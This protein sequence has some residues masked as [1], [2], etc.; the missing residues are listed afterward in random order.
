MQQETGDGQRVQIRNATHRQNR[1][2]IA[3]VNLEATAE[4]N[5][6]KNRFESIRKLGITIAE[7]K[8]S[9][10]RQQERELEENNQYTL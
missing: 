6:T 10:T 4:G 3:I 2:L 5:R 9:K 7:Q 8:H 1:L